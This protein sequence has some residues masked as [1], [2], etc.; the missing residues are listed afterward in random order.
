MRSLRL[1]VADNARSA[2]ARAAAIF[3]LKQLVGVK[4][5]DALAQAANAAD[6]RVRETALRALADRT[7]QLQGVSSAIFVKALA[8][9][10][11][12]VQVQAIRGLVRLGARDAAPALVTLTGSS[13]Q[14][15][16]H[17]A[18]NALVSL[19]ASDAVVKGLDATPEVRAGALRAMAMMR[20]PATVTAL[21]ERLGRATDAPSR[22]ALLHTLARL[23]NREGDWR[24]DWWTTRPAHLGPYFDPAP[25]EESPRIR[26]ALVSALAACDGDEFVNLVT[27]FA[28]NQVLPRGALPLLVAVTSARDPLRT[29]LIEAMVGRTQVDDRTLAIATQL[30]AQGLVMHNPVAQLLAGESNLSIA[31]LP[32]ARSAVLDQRIEQGTRASLLGAIGQ[33]SGPTALDGVTKVFAWMNPAPSTPPAAP[34]LQPMQWK[35]R[36]VAS[37]ATGAE[38]LSWTTS[39]TWPRRRSRRSGRSRTPYSFRAS[40]RRGHQRRFARRSRQ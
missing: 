7:D 4:A 27:D 26:A 28:R 30:D 1:A 40:E 14:A 35:Q 6:P 33:M 23:H 39:S 9:P 8:D 10:D 37:S 34:A 22:A 36:G 29:Q 25:W 11:P 15:L 31:A 19:D 21:I 38:R 24:G 5:N 12:Q 20:E 32:L 2:D 16:S 3:T 18:V 17:L 13:D